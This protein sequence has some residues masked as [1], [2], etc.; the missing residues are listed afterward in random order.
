MQRS[1]TTDKF[2]LG[3]RELRRRRLAY[4]ATWFAILPALF[5]GWLLQQYWHSHLPTFV[6]IFGVFFW[7]IDAQQSLASFRCPR[8]GQPFFWLYPAGRVFPPLGIP[9]FMQQRCASC[10]IPKFAS[11]PES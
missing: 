1:V 4:W 8:C 2:T 7:H 11:Q 3:W 10:G 9:V 5:I 6:L